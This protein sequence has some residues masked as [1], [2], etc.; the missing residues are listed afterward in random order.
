MRRFIREFTVPK[1]YLAEQSYFQWALIRGLAFGERDWIVICSLLLVFDRKKEFLTIPGVT[2][3][4]MGLMFLGPVFGILIYFVSKRIYCWRKKRARLPRTI[5]GLQ[6]IT[7][8]ANLICAPLIVSV[9]WLMFN[10]FYESY[11]GMKQLLL[12]AVHF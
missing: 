7:W 9:S 3:F 1:D 8:K 4:I 6:L 5:G 10:L 2:C 11:D 12:D